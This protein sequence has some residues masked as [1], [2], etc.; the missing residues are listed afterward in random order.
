MQ[1]FAQFITLK[2]NNANGFRTR[3]VQKEIIPAV[4]PQFL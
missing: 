2:I 4:S 1:L 3:R